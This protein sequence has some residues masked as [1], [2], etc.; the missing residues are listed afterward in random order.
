MRMIAYALRRYA[1]WSSERIA[2]CLHVLL[3]TIWRAAQRIFSSSPPCC[4]HLR[5]LR[6]PETRKLQDFL[7]A[8]PDNR[9]L[10]F[11]K[12]A[13][14]TGITAGEATIHRALKSMGYQQCVAV[15]KPDIK[16][17]HRAARLA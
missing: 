7:L 4:G 8:L 11:R 5:L 10:T 14:A 1:I 2:E 9:H 6:T 15:W 12:L 17:A 3:A 16:L 13:N